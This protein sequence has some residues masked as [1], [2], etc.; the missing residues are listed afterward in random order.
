MIVNS[1]F[2][3][4][5]SEGPARDPDQE[6]SDGSEQL[7]TGNNAILQGGAIFAHRY[8]P[9]PNTDTLLV[10]LHNSEFVTNTSDELGG[11]IYVRNNILDIQFSQFFGNAA[12]SGGLMAVESELT[13]AG[14]LFI[15]NEATGLAPSFQAIEDPATGIVYS[16]VL[17]GDYENYHSKLSEGFGGGINL[18]NTKTAMIDTRILGNTSSGVNSAGGGLCIN[19]GLADIITYSLQNCLIAG[20]T[21]EGRGGGVMVTNYTQ[22]RF[23]NCT[24]ADNTAGQFGG[25]IYVDQSS[26]AHIENSIVYNNT[27]TN[28]GQKPGGTFTWNDGDVLFGNPKFV[29]GPL[30]KYY[31]DPSSPAVNAGNTTAAAV[32]LGSYTTHPSIVPIIYDTGLVDLGYHYNPDE[33]SA[34]LTLTA[35]A[36]DEQG[37]LRGTVMLTPPPPYEGKYFF[38]QIVEMAVSLPTDYVVVGWSG[39]TI[40]DTSAATTNKVLMTGDKAITVLVRQRKTYFVG[41]STGLP[42][43]QD[44]IDAAK[45]G[46]NILVYPGS[47]SPPV[48][49]GEEEPF[50][51]DPKASLSLHGKSVRISGLNPDDEQMVSATV[52]SRYL[53]DL[54]GTTEETVI[55]G[56]TIQ[57]SRVD[58]YRGSPIIR[59]VVIRECRWVGITESA[60][61]DCANL[62]VDGANGAS[63]FGGAVTIIEGAPRFISC[64]FEENFVQGGDGQDGAGGCNEHPEGGDGG[65]P[66]RAYGGAVY[67]GFNSRPVFEHCT[68]TG[69][70]AIGG[71]GGNGGNGTQGA[72]GGR[73]GGF[74]F[75]P[76]IENDP[77]LWS[78]W[79]GWEYGDI[80]TLYSAYFGRYDWELWSK[81][82][83][84]D[85][86]NSWQEFLTSALA[87]TTPDI[88]GYED[89]WK[90]T[91]LGGAVYVSYL[92]EARFVNCI[93]ENNQTLGG[94]TGAGGTSTPLPDRQLNVPNAGGAVYAAHDSKLVFE[95]SRFAGNLADRST[96]EIPL[97]YEVSFGGA[98]AYEHDSEVLFINT[99]FEDNLAAVGG[100]IFGRDSTVEIANSSILNNEAFLGRTLS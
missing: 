99:E 100:A 48:G 41:G 24:I 85:K 9:G 11:A 70:Q 44:A 32:A 72:N 62:V 96:V 54:T 65:W 57:Q 83:G 50:S 73:G 92:S 95:N 23:D 82:F 66:G 94:L 21:S 34:Q 80:Y 42:T 76:S 58:I 52:F 37:Q 53:F 46:D 28:F 5:L 29:N 15:D 74:L 55:E 13:M 20:N 81:W 97:T 90:Y 16:I 59:N 25:G 69:N 27:P 18:I 75:P 33:H 2:V 89:Y 36:R 45:D 3:G 71:N 87:T 61:H 49:S 35:E 86:W 30:G 14:G 22:P 17:L 51:D 19:G 47:Y 10:N 84:L 60:S 98:L 8:I 39:G 26:G 38:G 31:L 78:W 64:R 93:F 1:Q 43:I 67:V 56:V 63:V 77:E 68:F 4:N 40:N 12:Y 7:V 79:D 6:R 91:G 88:D